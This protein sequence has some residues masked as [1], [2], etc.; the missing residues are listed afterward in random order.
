[1]KISNPLQMN[2]WEIK[3]FLRVLL[4]IQFAVWGA[5]G[6]DAIGLQIPIIRQ[7]I[8]FIYLTFI[9]CI[10]ILRNLK[11]QKQPKDTNSLE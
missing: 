2:D 10:L 9:P 11:L 3:K 1:M 8:G 4:A 5:I 6:L 7:F